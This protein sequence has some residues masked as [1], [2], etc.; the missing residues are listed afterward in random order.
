MT[1]EQIENRRKAIQYYISLGIT[2]PSEIAKQL[3][4]TSATICNDMK[5]MGIRTRER[6]NHSLGFET[7]EGCKIEEV[8]RKEVDGIYH[9]TIYFDKRDERGSRIKK[10]FSSSSRGKVESQLQEYLDHFEKV[11]EKG[12]QLQFEEPKETDFER[13][14]STMIS[15]MAADIA[16]IKNILKEI[17]NG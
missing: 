5:S 8:I 14:I 4:C 2:S 6:S 15:F 17:K 1:K 9:V 16:E 12:E 7:F 10:R 3:G 13:A 11:E